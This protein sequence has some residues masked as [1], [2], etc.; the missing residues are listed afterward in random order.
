MDFAPEII[1]GA[2]ILNAVDICTTGSD[3][4]PCCELAVGIHNWMVANGLQY[5]VVDFQDEK[6][7]CSTVLTEILQLRKRLQYPFVFCGLMV[8]P[9]K[10]LESYAYND[11]PIFD[12]PEEAVSY[13]KKHYPT[14]LMAD[15]SRIKENEA[16]PCTRSRSYRGEEE[17][18]TIDGEGESELEAEA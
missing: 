8:S 14:L 18:D 3:C 15:L 5:L 10:I 12:I 7:V 9:R 16:I 2:V 17:G 4:R 6:E 1:D 11:H 13:L